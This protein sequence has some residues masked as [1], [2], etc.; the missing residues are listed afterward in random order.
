[1]SEHKSIAHCRYPVADSFVEWYE[2]SAGDHTV[3]YRNNRYNGTS[4]AM[5][6]IVFREF[7]AAAFADWEA[8]LEG[9]A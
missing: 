9:S 8:T 6:E 3:E 1:M 2:S 7:N 4:R 5:A